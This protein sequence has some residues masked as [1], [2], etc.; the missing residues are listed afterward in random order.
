MLEIGMKGRAEMIVKTENTAGAMGSGEL[1]VLAT[2]AMI[3]LAEK[4]AWTSVA[5][6]LEE[7]QGTVGTKMDMAHISATP[8]GMKV[9]CESELTEI[10]RKRL[11]FRVVAYDEAGKI[12]EGMHERFI[13]DNKRFEEKANGKKALS[14]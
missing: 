2:P 4:S 6:E 5:G 1:S 11:V 10:D 8:V 12:G 9:W 3:A 7:G 14:E 13:V